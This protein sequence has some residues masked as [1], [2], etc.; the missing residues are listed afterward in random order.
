MK[1]SL[2]LIIIMMNLMPFSAFAGYMAGNSTPYISGAGKYAFKIDTSILMLTTPFSSANLTGKYGITDNLALSIKAGV[3][4][5]DYSTVTGFKLTTDPQ[6]GG[7]EIE[8]LLIGNRTGECT[9]AVF[10]YETVAWSINKKSN[11]STE[12]MMGMDYATFVDA[13][14]RTRFRLALHNF[15]AG[16]ESEKSM[17]TSLKYSLATEI[18][19]NFNSSFST[20]V[21]GAIY[22]GDVEGLI[23]SFGFGLGLNI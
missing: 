19:Y 13:N 15:N 4:T 23:A 5:V 21:G 20:S 9:S 16:T 2:I 11:S 6:V 22:F 14:T 18:D 17:D 10:G 12:I 3:G 1:K 8:Y 7:G